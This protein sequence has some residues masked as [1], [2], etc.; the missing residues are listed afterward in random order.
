MNGIIAKKLGMS[1]IFSEDGECIPVTVLEAGPC[2]VVR[3]KTPEV[4]GYSAIQLGYGDAKEQ[5]VSKPDMG[6]FKKAGVAPKK[7]LMEVSSDDLDS[8]PVGSEVDVSIFADAEQV[9]VSGISKGRGFSGTIR[10]H[11][12]SKGPRTHGSHNVRAPGSIGAC[13]YPARVFPGKRMPGQYGAKKITVRNLDVV[14]VDSDRN[15][16]YVRGAVPGSKNGIIMVRK[17]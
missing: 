3:H 16:L 17:G 4:D 8:W 2:V 9:N 15:L 1:Q 11:G 7:T 5:R 6:Q 14:K 10:R 12:F 13:S